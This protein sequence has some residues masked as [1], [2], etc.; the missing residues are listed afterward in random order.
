MCSCCPS[1]VDSSKAE[2]V[3]ERWSLDLLTL[4][5]HRVHIRVCRLGG[6]M[7]AQEEP[8]DTGPSGQSVW[9]RRSAEPKSLQTPETHERSGRPLGAESHWVS[10]LRERIKD[11]LGDVFRVGGCSKRVKLATLF[12]LGHPCPA[13]F[14]VQQPAPPAGQRGSTAAAPQESRMQPGNHR[15]LPDL[16]RHRRS[17]NIQSVTPAQAVIG[18]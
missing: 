17:W 15:E 11:H 10:R 6:C 4:P 18:R 2:Q 16:L 14:W 3:L 9:S 7:L 5:R 1:P 12:S 8:L 13:L